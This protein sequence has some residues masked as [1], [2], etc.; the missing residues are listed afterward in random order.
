MTKRDEEQMMKTKLKHLLKSETVLIVATILAII[1]MFFNPPSKEY[2]EFIDFRVLGILLSLMLVMAGFQ[3]NNVFKRLGEMLVKRCVNTWMLIFVLVF[4]CFFSSMLLTNDVALITFVP[5]A[6]LTLKMTHMENMMVHVVVLQTIAANLGS[7]LTP[8]G[9]PQNLY[10]YALSGMNIGE[11]IWLMLPYT[12]A[13]AI[14]L[15]VFIFFIKK[16]PLNLEKIGEDN[17]KTNVWHIIIYVALFVLCILVVLHIV[18]WYIITGV[19]VLVMLV[20]DRRVFA[21]ADYSLLLTFISFFIFIGNMGE[22][23][24]VRN[25]LSKLILGSELMVSIISSQVVSNV[26]A[27]ILLSGF[28]NDYNALIIGTN[29]GGLGTLIA[30][31]A[32]L[33]SYKQLVNMYPEKKGTYFKHFTVMNI[34]FLSVLVLI[35]VGGI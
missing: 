19:V 9:N 33:I 18:E 5:F 13:S 1:S 28:T 22:I 26:P 14:L 31:M 12:I 4:M 23:E 32:S 10:L 27:A 24:V 29:F 30:S 6:I 11:F 20:I 2:I 34:L 15:T 25:M 35:Y 3:I 17:G 8:M 7:M 21:K 16:K